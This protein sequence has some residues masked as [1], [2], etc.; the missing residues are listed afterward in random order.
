M[1]KCSCAGNSCSCAVQVGDGLTITG[2]GNAGAPF[3]I[4]L[5]QTIVTIAQSGAGALDLSAVKTGSIVLVN[6][7]ASVTSV[8]LPSVA[9]SRIDVVFK[10]VTASNTVAWGTVVKWPGGTA[11]VVSTT[12]NYMDWFVLRSLSTTEWIGAIEGQAIR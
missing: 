1:P 10:Q 11:P 8:V 4:S 2:T 3:T 7:S 12:I 5:T 6:L 9:G